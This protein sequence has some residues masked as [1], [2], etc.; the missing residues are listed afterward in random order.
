MNFSKRSVAVVLLGLLAVTLLSAALCRGVRARTGSSLDPY[1]TVHEWGT[2]TS[3]A[4]N[5]GRAVQWI[6]QDGSTDLPD[7]VEHLRGA[8]LKPGLSGTVRMETPVMYFYSPRETT[9]S[10]RVAFSKGLI[11]EWYPHAS[12]AKPTGDLQRVSLASGRTTGSLAWDEIQLQPTAADD[13]PRDSAETHYYAARETSATPLLVKSPSGD[14]RE[15]FLFYR[16]VAAFSVPVSVEVT[17][18]GNLLLTNLGGQTIPGL[19]LFERRGQR[20]GFRLCGPLESELTLEPPEL[21]GSVSALRDKFEEILVARG[22]YRDEAHAMLATWGDSWFQEGTRVFYMVP[23]AF[24]NAI[25]P[26]SIA[27]A[28]AQIARVFVGRVEV[29]SPLTQAE[30]E[31]ALA[32]HDDTTLAKFGRFLTPLLNSMMEGNPQKAREIREL[33]HPPAPAPEIARRH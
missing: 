24:V 8:S 13:F 25:L 15:K 4:G 12:D 9:V 29:A 30:I 28:P 5:D 26:L 23:E 32:A 6:P 2:F 27:P 14:Q 7:F 17:T 18:Q 1:L 33:L 3:I 22:L 20:V 31:A 19:I 10:V 21:N 16:G 11:T